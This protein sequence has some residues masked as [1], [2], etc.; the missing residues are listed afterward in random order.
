M[1]QIKTEVKHS[2]TTTATSEKGAAVTSSGPAVVVT[3]GSRLSGV[4]TLSKLIILL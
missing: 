2:S 3:I 4:V 1:G